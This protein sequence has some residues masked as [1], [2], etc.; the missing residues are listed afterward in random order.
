MPLLI[1]EPE[2]ANSIETERVV[3]GAD[4]FDEVWES[5][6]VVMPDPNNEHQDLIGLLVYCFIASGA[7]L[8]VRVHPG[9][10]V[11]DRRRGWKDN[12]R[13]PDIAVILQDGKA[14]DCGPYWYLGPDLLTEILS[15][16]DGAREKLEFYAKIGVMEWLI[17]DRDPWQLELYRNWDG[18]PKL[19]GKSTVRNGLKLTS[20]VLNLRFHL[21]KNAKRPKIAI[22]AVDGS[23]SWSA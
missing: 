4:R 5:T 20:E 13:C 10:N 1:R 16:D 12:Y 6:Y 14:N 22:A 3:V 15:P 8:G 11:S 2:L 9:C 21:V 18:I 23:G 7:K 17:V 19:V